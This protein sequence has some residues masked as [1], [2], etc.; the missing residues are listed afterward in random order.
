MSKSTS[1]AL[2]TGASSGLGIELARSLAARGSNLVLT[3]RTAAPMERLAG[4]LG[5]D[6]GIEAVVEPLDLS[7]PGSAGVLA[8][9][10]DA[11]GIVPDILVNNAGFGLSG[12]FIDHDPVRLAAMLQLN[13]VSLTELAQIFGRRMAAQGRG[14]ILLTASLAAFQPDPLLAAYGASKAY[15]LSLGEALNVELGPKVT[16]T[17]LSPGLMD[18]GFNAVADFETPKAFES[19]KLEPAEVARIGLDALFRGRSS[20]V[21]GRIN[22][23]AA[24]GTRLM[25]RHAAARMT[26]GLSGG[27]K[28]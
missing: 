12:R 19:S 18:T 4:E 27:A 20:V 16:V 28:A 2:I 9:R 26:F 24:F 25:S 21:A 7:A 8:E 13:I 15:V 23:V 11:R 5:R 22:R 6:H 17:V 10:L 3:A 14:R 1:W